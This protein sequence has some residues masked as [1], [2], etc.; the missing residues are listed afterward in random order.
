MTA[1]NAEDRPDPAPPPGVGCDTPQTC[2]TALLLIDLVNDLEFP[3]GDALFA[4]LEPRLPRIAGLKRRAADAGAACV[5]VNDNFGHWRSDFPAT[6]RHCLEDGVRGEPVVRAL[7]PGDD[8][9]FVLKPRHSGFY[10]TPLEVLL[11]HLGVRRVVLCGVAANICVLMTAADAFVRGFEVVVPA[12]G[13]ASNT[14][15]L[16]EVALGQ[17]RVVCKADTPRCAEVEFRDPD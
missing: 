2:G 11:R 3:E 16:T 10:A 15:D 1:A 12:D 9:Y 6:V 14:A 13:V 17:V 8:D 5:Y 4:Q 7:A